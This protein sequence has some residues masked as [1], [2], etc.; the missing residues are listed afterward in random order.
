MNL[1]MRKLAFANV[2]RVGKRNGMNDRPLRIGTRGSPLAL[3]QAHMVRDRLA[4]AFPDAAPAQ[5]VEI[6]T[7]GDA[8]TDRPLADAGGKGL[9]TKEIDRALIDGD[10]DIGVHSAK[11]ME[12]WLAA[13]MVIGAALEREDPRDVLI[14]ATSIEAIPQGAKVG[15]A[16]QR[17]QAQL[18]A[19]RPDI[20]VVLFR[21]NVQTRLRKLSEGEADVTL[22]ALAGLNRLGK[23]DVADAV[24]EAEEM[25]PA[26][27]QGIV[28]IAHMEDDSF[29]ADAV[30]PLNDDVALICLRA[31]RAMLDALD[32]TCRTPIAGLARLR[33]G[34]LQLDGLVAW[35]DGSDLVR[36]AGSGDPADPEGLGRAL[37]LELR[38][39]IGDGFFEAL[40][41]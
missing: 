13:G 12:T 21:G 41:D 19:R 15:T 39:L 23:A 22:L 2:A 14:G 28:A 9:F 30:A 17:R 33:G 37:G 10:V 27:G 20:D 4:A 32:G 36:R 29:A 35:P 5:I 18:L 3:A 31:E 38:G 16:S 11:D 26:A 34:T 25:L 1:V 8:V 24:L 7:T 6:K 40:A